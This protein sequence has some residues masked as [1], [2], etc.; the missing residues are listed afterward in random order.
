MVQEKGKPIIGNDTLSDFSHQD[1]RVQDKKHMDHGEFSTEDSLSLKNLQRHQSS[2][3][4]SV[5]FHGFIFV[6][7]MFL[8]TSWKI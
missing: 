6:F 3:P 2:E 1:D 4:F 5:V 8:Y 7:L